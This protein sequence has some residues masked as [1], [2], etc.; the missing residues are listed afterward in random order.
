MSQEASYG[1]YSYYPKAAERYVAAAF[2]EETGDYPAYSVIA[3][4]SLSMGI[5]AAKELGAATVG[6]AVQHWVV[7]G[8]AVDGMISCLAGL[9]IHKRRFLTATF[10]ILLETWKG[11]R[12]FQKG[13]ALS[14]Q[15]ISRNL[16]FFVG[17]YLSYAKIL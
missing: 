10:P 12:D 8:K 15:N 5:R 16:L 4:I 7:N 3:L 6:G 17:Y 11:L 14:K 2:K 13:K 9:Q 1:D